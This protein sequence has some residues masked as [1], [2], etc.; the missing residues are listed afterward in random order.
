MS[1]LRI[2]Y[3]SFQA[4]PLVP[5][6]NRQFVHRPVVDILLMFGNKSIEYQVLVDSGADFCIF[7]T[8][9]ANILGIP[10]TQGKR[11]TFYGTGGIPQAAYF[12]DI[13]MEIYGWQMDLYAGFSS[14]MKSLPYG[15]LGQTGFFDQFKVEFDYQNKRLELKP[16]R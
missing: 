11:M 15:I 1:L 4:T 10:V 5:F 16:K 13:R 9:M 7:H 12:N 2:A 3:K 14:E 6:P 8:E